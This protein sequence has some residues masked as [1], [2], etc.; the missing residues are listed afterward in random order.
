MPGIEEQK[1]KA[2]GTT[3]FFFRVPS[4]RRTLTYLIA[5]C[6][7]AGIANRALYGSISVSGLLIFGGADGILL[8]GLPAL[9]AAL[10]AAGVTS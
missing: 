6:F 4:P 2:V 9:F 5:S 10:L 7:L 1:R 8:L 3:K